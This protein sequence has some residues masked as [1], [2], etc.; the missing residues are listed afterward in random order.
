M[1]CISVVTSKCSS[2][3]IHPALTLSLVDDGLLEAICLHVF[4]CILKG[5]DIS[6]GHNQPSIFDHVFF[7]T[8]DPTFD[9]MQNPSYGTLGRFKPPVPDGEVVNS[10]NSDE[11]IANEGA[12]YETLS[13]NQD[14]LIES[15]RNHYE[16]DHEIVL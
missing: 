5:N 3:D 11:V 4:Q 10:S 9:G 8:K 15:V 14:E 12:V 1:D 2:P 16:A 7:C 6:S 13:D